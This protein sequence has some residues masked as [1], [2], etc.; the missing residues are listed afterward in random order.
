MCSSSA[1]AAPKPK[2]NDSAGN[3]GDEPVPQ[4]GLDLILPIPALN[5]DVGAHLGRSDRDDCS[6]CA[7]SFSFRSRA[8]SDDSHEQLFGGR[9][10]PLTHQGTGAAPALPMTLSG[11][12]AGH[13]DARELQ[14]MHDDAEDD[15]LFLETCLFRGR[16]QLVEEE[17]CAKKYEVVPPML[18]AGN[19]GASFRILDDLVNECS[20]SQDH[21]IGEGR[22]VV[23]GNKEGESSGQERQ[24]SSFPGLQLPLPRQPTSAEDIAAR[25][26]NCHN[27]FREEITM[28]KSLDHPSI[29]KLYDV[30][31]DDHTI[32]LIMEHCDRGELMDKIDCD[33]GISEVE[34]MSIVKQVTQGLRYCHEQNI[35][36]RDIKPENILFKSS[37]GRDYVKLIDFGISAFTGGLTNE[38]RVGTYAYV[39]PEVLDEKHRDLDSKVDMWALGVVMYVMLSGLMPFAGPSC[40]SDIVKG[41]YHPLNVPEVSD[42]AKDLL[43]RLLTVDPATRYNAQQVL[44]H[45]WLLVSSGVEHQ[46][47][48]IPHAPSMLTKMPAMNTTN[49]YLRTARTLKLLNRLKRFQTLSLFR[50]LTLT[51]IAVKLVPDLTTVKGTENAYEKSILEPKEF[52]ALWRKYDDQEGSGGS[53]AGGVS[54][55]RSS[56]LMATSSEDRYNVPRNSNNSTAY[57]SSTLTADVLVPTSGRSVVEEEGISD[58]A[59]VGGLLLPQHEQSHATPTLLPILPAATPTTCAPRKNSTSSPGEVG[60]SCKSKTSFCGSVASLKISDSDHDHLDQTITSSYNKKSDPD[61][62]RLLRLD[63][64][65]HQHPQTTGGERER[66]HEQDVGRFGSARNRGAALT[67]WS[68]SI[69]STTA[70]TMASMSDVTHHG[71]HLLTGEKTGTTS[72]TAN[73]NNSSSEDGISISLSTSTALT[74]D[75][76]PDASLRP[77]FSL[78]T[79]FEFNPIRELEDEDIV[80]PTCGSPLDSAAEQDHCRDPDCQM[81][82][83]QMVELPDGQEA[84]EQAAQ[85]DATVAPA[86]SSRPSGSSSASSTSCASSTETVLASQRALEVFRSLDFNQEGVLHY[87]QVVAGVINDK[88]VLENDDI[89]WMVWRELTHPNKEQLYRTNTIA[90]A[91][92]SAAGGDHGG[93]AVARSY[94]YSGE[95][96]SACSP[97]VAGEDSIDVS[98]FVHFLGEGSREELEREWLLE[99]GSLRALTYDEF[100][101]LLV[102]GNGSCTGCATS[103]ASATKGTNIGTAGQNRESYQNQSQSQSGFSSMTVPTAGT[104]SLSPKSAGGGGRHTITKTSS[105][106]CARLLSWPEDEDEQDSPRVLVQRRGRE[107]QRAEGEGHSGVGSSSYH[108]VGTSAPAVLGMLMPAPGG[109]E[110]WGKTPRRMSISRARAVSTDTLFHEALYTPRYRRDLDVFFHH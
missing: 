106:N 51:I 102:Y 84:H 42:A 30:V 50:R 77:G 66:D 48:H 88:A 39:S 40:R 83:L 108:V 44:D 101:K 7:S 62:F 81:V 68:P 25:E 26:N 69:L 38:F 49:C 104:A 80:S 91:T 64:V 63:S 107:A 3:C 9:A 24:S 28:M 33:D 37:R 13:A 5:F 92:A 110:R 87:T 74:V 65:D 60:S 61:V 23:G 22:E 93:G 72:T 36:H 79:H 43:S 94:S 95:S 54:G 85:Q 19:Q 90:S 52:V 57:L 1:F 47:L 27:H 96:S 2:P 20:E 71:M 100:K 98:H 35:V 78:A 41:Q 53:A 103:T 10:T 59:V 89:M 17:L 105:D 55:G 18:A 70:T 58:C 21:V 82:E 34:T 86:S 73:R 97:T 75:L 56:M 31:E 14:D 11:T 16:R 46:H 67:E 109:A 76:T 32:Y 12:T 4:L 15:D 6:D 29:C 8:S 45:P 99:V